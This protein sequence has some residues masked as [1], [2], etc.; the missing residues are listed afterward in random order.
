M[1]D[2]KGNFFTVDNR[3]FDY[4]LKP[5]DIAVYCCICRHINRETGVAF[6]SRRMIARECGIGKVDTVDRAIDALIA[7]GLLEK[8]HQMRFDGGYASNVYTLSGIGDM[9]V[10]REGR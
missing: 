10:P 9:G 6:P 3:I 4:G 5:R 1:R 2:G 8:K 7:K